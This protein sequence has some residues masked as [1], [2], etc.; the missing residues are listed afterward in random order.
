[1][2][3]R[4][5]L[6]APL[7]TAASVARGRVLGVSGPSGSGKTRLLRALADLEPSEGRIDLAGTTPA[8]KTAPEW[9]RRVRYVPAEPAWW[10]E[11]LA[12]HGVVAPGLGLPQDRMTAPIAELSTGE[13]QRGALLRAALGAPEV[14]LLDEPTSALDPVASGLVEDWIA[15]LTEGGAIVILVSHDAE[16]L[17]R[18]ADAVLEIGA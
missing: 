7:A 9:R 8:T 18:C 13:R 14:L 6:R 16:Q 5:D 17:A 3:F 2:T 12:A 10:G 11:S 15:G 4:F 1:M